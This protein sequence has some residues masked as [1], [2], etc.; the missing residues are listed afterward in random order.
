MKKCI[1]LLLIPLLSLAQIDS[2]TTRLDSVSITSYR[3][4]DDVLVLP[5][6]VSSLRF[7]ESVTR[8]ST[9]KQ[10]LNLEEYLNA[11]PGLFTLNSNNYA[12]DLRISIRGFGARSA[13][14]IRGIKLIVDG[15]PET[16]PD[17]QGQIDNLNLGVIDRIEVLRGP[18]AILYGNASGGAIDIQTLQHL[19]STYVQ[20]SG[21]A[22]S[23]GMQQQQV[24]A[25]IA[26]KNSITFLNATRT[27]TDGYRD[28]N[29]FE[30]YNFNIKHKR[31]TNNHRWTFLANYADS[32][33]AEDPGS[34]DASAVAADRRQSR[35]RNTLFDTEESVNQ[36]KSGISHETTIG[37]LEWKNYAFY[38]YRDFNARLP[39]ENGGDIDLYR[40]YGGVGTALN[41]RYGGKKLIAQSQV[42]VDYGYQRDARRRFDNLEGM[43]GDLALNQD[44]IFSGLGAYLH[45]RLNYGKWYMLGGLRYDSNLLKVE[46]GFL[47]D[48][49]ASDSVILDAW[50]ASMGITY[51]I[52]NA[53]SIYGNISTSFE[54][55]ALSELSADPT[56]T[57]GFNANLQPQRATNY[58]LGYKRA[59]ATASAGLALFYISTRDDLVPFEIAQFPDRTFFRNAGSSDRL[60][61]EL[62]VEQKLWNHLYLL[63]SYAYSDFT[64]CDYEVNGRN[65]EGNQLPGIPRHL[66]TLQLSYKSDDLYLQLQ[67]TLRGSFYADDANDTREDEVHILNVSGSYSLYFSQWRLQPFAGINNLTDHRYSDNVRINA[68]SGRFFE[69][70][71][72]M[73]FYG[74]VR[75]RL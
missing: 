38:S 17:G 18:A 12:Q 39:F 71:P 73:N 35:D 22:G 41:Y 45:Q 7:R 48:G 68:F 6:S 30:S 51:K 21:T 16:T 15:I 67:N 74:G 60:G 24:T 10:Q 58:E 61:V 49:D 4:K 36:F 52:N 62:S 37:R 34:L 20:A 66:A 43:R 50:S 29:G 47:I 1:F 57:G 59:S 13:F 70:A 42:G 54:T 23:Y 8:N 5:Y 3:G 26:G 69:P 53:S 27:A 9:S 40:N 14:G 2:T 19:D 33:F 25:G 65:F 32:P 56:N 63:G 64:Y 55:P 75:V 72:G 44:E 31:Q 46:D 11:V 28:R